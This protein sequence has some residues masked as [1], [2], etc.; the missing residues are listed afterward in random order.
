M[1]TRGSAGLFAPALAV[2]CA[3]LPAAAL[4]Q[5]GPFEPWRG[6][7]G[8]TETVAQIMARET[9]KPREYE[10]DFNPPVD[11]RRLPHNPASPHTATWPPD[12]TPLLN[13][14]PVWRLPVFDGRSPQTISVN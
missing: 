13:G 6:E 10:T 3:G 1:T 5:Q 11:R 9:V 12:A 14:P 8:I 2:A 7:M 4:A